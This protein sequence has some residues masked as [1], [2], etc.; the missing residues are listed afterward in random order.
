MSDARGGLLL[1]F[2]GRPGGCREDPGRAAEARWLFLCSWAQKESG[3]KRLWVELMDGR[4]LAP[5]PG[6]VPVSSQA[7]Q[8]E[9][10]AVP[11]DETGT[12]K[13]GALCT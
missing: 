12:A 7:Q 11:R 2:S 10:A 1:S 8:A 4:G 5:G 13:W 9:A 3:K 6:L